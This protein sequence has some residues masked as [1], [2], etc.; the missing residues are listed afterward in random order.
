ML[1]PEVI[2]LQLSFQVWPCL[3]C[4]CMLGVSGP[5]TTFCTTFPVFVVCVCVKKKKKPC[6]LMDNVD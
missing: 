5:L 6:L 2:L 3:T 1:W 4:L